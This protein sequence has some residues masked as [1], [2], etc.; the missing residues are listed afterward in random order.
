[1]VTG[2]AGTGQLIWQVCCGWSTNGSQRER[3]LTW[4]RTAWGQLGDSFESPSGESGFH[5]ID[6]RKPL[7]VY[8]MASSLWPLPKITL[9][10]QE[11][12]PGN[13][14]ESR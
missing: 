6:N 1:M 11:G 9:S 13:R 8:R 12:E 3:L 7:E 14:Q 10:L 2:K 4:G 5:S